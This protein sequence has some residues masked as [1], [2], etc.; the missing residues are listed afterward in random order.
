MIDEDFKVYLIE[1]NT[2]PCLE[3]SS[4]LLARVI[5]NLIDNVLRIAIDPILPPP[6]FSKWSGGKKDSIIDN[7]IE[8]NKF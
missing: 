5:P 1:A 6:D 7:S 8:S 3:I 2:N 4:T